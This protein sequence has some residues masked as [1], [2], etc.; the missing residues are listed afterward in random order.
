MKSAR[1]RVVIT[2]MGILAPNGNS[3]DEFWHNTL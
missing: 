3:L 2:G 1:N